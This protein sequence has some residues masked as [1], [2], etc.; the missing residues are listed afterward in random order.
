VLGN[1]ATTWRI[2]GGVAQDGGTESPPI[3]LAPPVNADTAAPLPG[4]DMS[5]AVARLGSSSVAGTTT[6][7][8]VSPRCWSVTPTAP[9]PK[10]D[11]L[12]VISSVFWIPWFVVRHDLRHQYL[13]ELQ[14][15]TRQSRIF[16]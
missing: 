8:L 5:A 6:D 3:E 12:H 16:N 2:A 7:G 1:A 14:F 10:M 11:V 13:P 9:W 4:L 15:P